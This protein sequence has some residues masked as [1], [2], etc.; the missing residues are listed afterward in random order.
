MNKDDNLLEK[1]YSDIWE[2]FISAA[3]FLVA[4]VGFVTISLYAPA[5]A[6]FKFLKAILAVLFCFFSIQIFS[7]LKLI[8]CY[9][10]N[11]GYKSALQTWLRNLPKAGYL[12]ISTLLFLAIIVFTPRSYAILASFVFVIVAVFMYSKIFKV[13]FWKER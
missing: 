10:H 8:T 4:L 1:K 11:N 6:S 5:P 9:K 2:N 3:S 7:L 12:A 13:P